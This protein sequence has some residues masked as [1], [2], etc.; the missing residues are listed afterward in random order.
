[1]RLL[2]ID[3]HVSVAQVLRDALREDGHE[4]SVA[5]TGE[6]GLRELTRDC[7]DA[8]FLD[9]PLPEMNGVAVLREIRARD[10]RLPVI[11]LSGRAEPREI[12]ELQRLGVSGVLWKTEILNHFDDAL[13]SLAGSPRS[14]RKSFG[15]D[16]N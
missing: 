9:V 6:D 11:I 13:A 10:P 7:P 5:H 3:D 12:E 16:G 2:L 1:M 4:V 15:N 8:V 14:W